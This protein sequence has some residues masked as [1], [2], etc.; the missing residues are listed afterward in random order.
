MNARP[1]HILFFSKKSANPRYSD[2]AG[3]NNNNPETIRTL[4]KKNGSTFSTSDSFPML[5]LNIETTPTFNFRQVHTN[6]FLFYHKKIEES[7]VYSTKQDNPPERFCA[8]QNRLW[9]KADNA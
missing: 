8:F 4:K 5:N 3:K 2:I 7:R 9:G 6:T 1:N